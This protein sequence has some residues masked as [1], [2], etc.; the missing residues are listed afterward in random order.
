MD[1]QAIRAA[2]I[3]LQ[4]LV[5]FKV[6]RATVDDLFKAAL[7]PTGLKH[8]LQDGVIEIFPAKDAKSVKKNGLKVSIKAAKPVFEENE[9]LAFDV[10]FENV[11]KK[12]YR[13]NETM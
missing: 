1:E 11:S 9:P 10:T 3:D 4:K 8:R 12:P 2:G 6:V 7:A 5:S 13:L